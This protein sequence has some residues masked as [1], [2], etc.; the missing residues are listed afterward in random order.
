MAKGI[1]LV[2]YV[3]IGSEPSFETPPQAFYEARPFDYKRMNPKRELH[4]L[5]K[6]L[7]SHLGFSASLPG[8]AERTNGELAF[9]AHGSGLAVAGQPPAWSSHLDVLFGAA[10]FEKK[11]TSGF[12]GTIAADHGGAATKLS[13]AGEGA[14]GEK[15]KLGAALIADGA[16]KR[17]AFIAAKEASGSDLIL[18]L[19]RNIADA[20]SVSRIYGSW[21]FAADSSNA[22]KADSSDGLATFALEQEDFNGAVERFAGCVCD[23]VEISAKAKGLVD[24]KFGFAANSGSPAQSL[25]AVSTPWVQPSFIVA[26]NAEIAVDGKIIDFVEEASLKLALEARPLESIDAPNGR[27]GCVIA[28][29]KPTIKI[30]ARQDEDFAD[31][32][33]LFETA[34]LSSV[35]MIFKSE[36]E[37]VPGK[38]LAVFAPRAQIL[39]PYEINDGG[40]QTRAL[41]FN[42]LWTDGFGDFA[43]SCV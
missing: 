18:T 43:V 16:K 23:R 25:S 17:V 39:K 15:Y 21:T 12:A 24:L 27:R 30:V 9:K 35:S 29:V 38:S 26:R 14:N 42:V 22:S 10:G 41:E 6:Q 28:S 37:A 1:P 20:G 31:V 3:Q 11:A 2:K 13:L 32:F 5:E 7:R 34:R 4:S 8:C 36:P 19:D 33:S 40:V